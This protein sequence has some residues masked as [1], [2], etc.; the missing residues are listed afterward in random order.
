MEREAL[1]AISIIV[2]DDDPE[3]L[4]LLVSYL[5]RKV[6][7]LYTATNGKEGLDAIIAHK[8]HVIITDLEMPEMNGLQMMEALKNADGDYRPVIVATGYN[9][10]EHKSDYADA[11]IFKPLNFK[12]LLELVYE[13]AKQYGKI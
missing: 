1:K 13:L 4:A 7:V 5:E 2:I 6:G 9:D 12:K 3:I 10:D 11:Y 8:P